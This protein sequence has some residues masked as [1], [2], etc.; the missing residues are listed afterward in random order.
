M[1][2]RSKIFNLIKQGEGEKLEWKDSKILSDPFKFSKSMAALANQKG[3]I[4][5][6]GVRD[7]GVL[8]NMKKKKGHE[9]HIMNI[10]VQNCDPPI[11]P[12]F[13]IVSVTNEADVY[14]IVVP[15]KKTN[16]NHGVKS[17]DGLVYFRR[18]GSTIREIPPYQMSQPQDEGVEVSPYTITYKGVLFLSDRLVNAISTQFNFSTIKSMIALFIIGIFSLFGG[19]LSFYRIKEGRLILFA[20]YPNWINISLLVLIILGIYLSISIPTSAFETRCP[21]CKLF[22][23]F[24]KVKTNVLDKRTINKD[25]EEWTVRNLYQCEACGYEKEKLEYKEYRRE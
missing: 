25:L 3:G 2:D 10:A 9:E 20:N 7:D 22:F 21:T 4:I 5:L 16:L 15:Q 1:I 8:E 11:K 17:K 18:V 6:I 19:L 14:V 12:I 24:K 13:Q 23:T